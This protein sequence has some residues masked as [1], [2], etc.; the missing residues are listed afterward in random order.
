[1]TRDGRGGGVSIGIVER[2]ILRATSAADVRDPGDSVK[3]ITNKKN[4]EKKV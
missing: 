3:K 1:M 2:E 4:W